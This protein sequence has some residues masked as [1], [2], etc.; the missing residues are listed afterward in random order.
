MT[1]FASDVRAPVALL[2]ATRLSRHAKLA[3]LVRRA[4]QRGDQVSLAALARAS[5]LERH[6]VR[7]VLPQLAEAG[8]DQAPVIDPWV[9]MP[10]DLLLDPNISVHARLLYGHLQLTPE[11]SHP[12]G[13]CTYAELR[14]RTGL[15]LNTIKQAMAKLEATGWLYRTQTTQKAP[16]MFTLTNPGGE[17]L[18]EIKQRIDGAQYKGETI[19]KEILNQLVDDKDYEDNAR[20]DFL[21]NPFTHQR[22]ELDRYYHTAAVALEFNGPQHDGPTDLATPEEVE[23]QRGRDLMK[24]DICRRRGITLIVVQATDLSPDRIRALLPKS[25]PLREPKAAMIASLNRVSSSYREEASR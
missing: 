6:T 1:V 19:M 15:A 2:T 22:M 16:V 4:L 3:W 17:E 8:W 11:F 13:C 18:A 20:P 25:L 14:Q 24:A 5:G 21:I 7:Q 10:M 12:E 9:P 23:R